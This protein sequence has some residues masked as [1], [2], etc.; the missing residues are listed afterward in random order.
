MANYVI[1]WL[2]F[3]AVGPGVLN[4]INDPR[5]LITKYVLVLGAFYFQINKRCIYIKNKEQMTLFF[6]NGENTTLQTKQTNKQTRETL[7]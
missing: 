2:V 3:R 1:E 7:G 5:S 4:P 6:L